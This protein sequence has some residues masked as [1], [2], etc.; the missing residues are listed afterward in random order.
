MS[1]SDASRERDKSKAYIEKFRH[2][3]VIVPLLLLV[4][5]IDSNQ[6]GVLLPSALYDR[7][8]LSLI[9]LLFRISLSCC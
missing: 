1:A 6:V 7:P 4:R 5:D 3:L 2:I 8:V 9:T